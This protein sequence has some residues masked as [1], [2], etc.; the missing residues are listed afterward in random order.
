MN[1]KR[2]LIALLGIP[3]LVIL[4]GTLYNLPP[5][6]R[7][8]AW[9]VDEWRARL[10]YAINPP[11]E[12]VF[13]P[14][15]VEGTETALPLP[16]ATYTPIPTATP[17]LH[18]PTA[19][20]APSATPTI[21]PT[22]LPESV[23]LDGVVYVDQHGRW[24][25]CGPA[26]LTMALKFWGW[27]GDRD[28]VARVVKPGV[29]DPGLDFIQ[30]GRWDKNVMPYEMAD[31]VVE[32]TDFNIVIRYGGTV[33]L[34]KRLIAGGF[35]VVVE[36]GYY[37]ADYTGK[38]AWLGHYLFTTGYD[39]AAGE[40]IVQ[41]A[42]LRPGK[43]MRVDY[44]TY[45]DGWRSFDYLFFVVYP[46]ERQEQL[47]NLL[48][49]WLDP[50]FSYQ[51]ALQTAEQEIQTQEGIDLFFAW[52]NKGTSLVKLQRY[53]EAAAA[54]DQ[55]FRVYAEL[56]EDDTQRPYRIMWYQTGPYWAYYYTGRYQD[57][58]NLANTT[59]YE[60][61]AEPTLEESLYWRGQAYLALGQT[62]DAIAD[63]REAVR[64]NPNFKAALA[65]LQQLGVSP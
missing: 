21:T 38:V 43:N 2:L 53:G 3:A 26:N 6:H 64:L 31:F 8:L 18:Q 56:Q 34:L 57:V 11:D 5:I 33:D 15:A 52:F 41:D 19:T 55:A 51:Y 27:P 30:Q 25:Y 35:P 44:Q 1:R 16:T 40:F 45:L 22:P 13:V 60:T 28:D 61:I 46:P 62:V 65:A 48:G 36:K 39:D 54:Y 12:A 14:A 10:K 58:I 23:I 17:S 49:D 29:Q 24:N 50:N 32:H 20:P 9:R 7:R 4:C 37:E 42:Y 59:L 47:F 63:F